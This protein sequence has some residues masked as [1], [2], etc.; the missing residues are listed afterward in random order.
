[1]LGPF[2]VRPVLADLQILMGLDWGIRALI[3]VIALTSLLGTVF[4]YL[5][6]GGKSATLAAVI[7][8]SYPVFV[9]LFTW[10]LFREAHINASVVIG[11]ALVF[12]GV[13]TIIL[14]NR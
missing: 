7:E 10:L 4:L 6:I 3:M 13:V 14:G 11:G 2:F 5:A 8:I 9:A 12:A 1:M